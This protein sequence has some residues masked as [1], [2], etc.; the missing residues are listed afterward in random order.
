MSEQWIFGQFGKG[1]GVAHKGAVKRGDRSKVSEAQQD[2][3]LAIYQKYGHKAARAICES[4]GL[5]RK[6]Y[7]DLAHRRGV[8]MVK[9]GAPALEVN[10]VIRSLREIRLAMGISQD[11][12]AALVAHNG[13]GWISQCESG[14]KTPT[15]AAVAK[16][17][18]ALGYRLT[19]EPKE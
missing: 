13:H 16:W 5:S 3:I 11:A 18:D 1:K 9:A 15:I 4:A 19:L 2:E 17:A 10:E 6:Y 8:S 14:K 7:T 12:V